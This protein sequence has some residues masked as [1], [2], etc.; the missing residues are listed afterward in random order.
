MSRHYENRSILGLDS[1]VDTGVRVVGSVL[2]AVPEVVKRASREIED[3]R[4]GCG[5]RR[6]GC[7]ARNFRSMQDDDAAVEVERC[8]TSHYLNR[9][10]LKTLLREETGRKKLRP[11]TIRRMTD[12]L[13]ASNKDGTEG[14]KAAGG[15]VEKAAEKV[16]KTAEGKADPVTQGNGSADPASTGSHDGANGG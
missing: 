5:T 9:R 15:Q 10:D 12:L 13:E 8:W 2:G 6:F 1:L 16:D 7:L 11:N 14:A 3:D 4:C